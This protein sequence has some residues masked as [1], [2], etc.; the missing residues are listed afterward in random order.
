MTPR[1]NV[2]IPAWNE[3][4]VITGL[5]TRLARATSEGQ[6][7]VIVI[8][9]ACTDDTADVARKANP[10]ALILETPEGGKANAMNLGYRA[11]IPG[12]PVVCVDAD[13]LVTAD[14]IL[15]L[16]TPLRD[17][18]AHAACGRM[19]PDLGGSSWAVR[20]F[21]E[22]WALNP[23]FAKGKFGG[24][25]ALSAHGA[26]RVFPLPR[27]T[28]D[29]EWVRRAFA[30]AE[31]AF[32]SGSRF[33]ARAP[34]DLATLIRL[35]R[36][37]LR[38]ARVVRA[39]VGQTGADHSNGIM[40]LQALGR[41]L[42]WPGTVIFILVMALVRWQLNRETCAAQAVWERDTGNRTAEARVK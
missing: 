33:F 8:A 3:A 27:V 4:N 32:V 15:A 40:L 13:L 12:L 29:D 36:R 30:P 21:Y 16:I 39:V 31:R 42:L 24:M 14:D 6:M 22:A 26:G 34:K 35:R 38:G 10:A 28:A 1:V 23:H 5:L 20:A 41:P 19:V 7:R 18:T 17:G 9:N 11:A 2:L 37:S 25:F